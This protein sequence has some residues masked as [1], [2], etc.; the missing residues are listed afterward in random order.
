MK[1]VLYITLLF[2]P[3][4]ARAN[5]IQIYFSPSNHCENNIV[6]FI[7]KSK[8]QIDVAI[9][10]LN[11]DRIVEAL[12]KAHKRSV[13][14]RILTDRLQASNRSSKVRELHDYG[15]NIR[16]HS[17]HRIEHNKFA[18]FDKRVVTSGSFNWTNPATHKNSENCVFFIRNKNAVEEY[19]ERFDYLWRVNTKTKSDLWFDK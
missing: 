13:K 7:N 10:S 3:F 19:Q 16:V 8:K 11:N 15:I 12:K 4:F 6:R 17:K 5:D 2:L 18:I 1:L 9:Y 14:I